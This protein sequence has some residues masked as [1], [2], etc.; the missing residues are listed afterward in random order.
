MNSNALSNLNVS[1][2]L[3][4]YN[5]NFVE[6]EIFQDG[7]N[8]TSCNMLS[9]SGNTVEFS[10]HHFTNYTVVEGYVAPQNINTPGSGSSGSTSGNYESSSGSSGSNTGSSTFTNS[11]LQSSANSV[12][13]SQNS[14][15]GNNQQTNNSNSAIN[16]I[17]SIKSNAIYYIIAFVVIAIITIISLL[18][19]NKKR[20]EKE[21]LE[22]RSAIENTDSN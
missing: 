11:N 1:A 16:T 5:I 15:N 3:T 6:P 22:L 12:I 21:S 8:C 18:V 13:S 7:I 20:K 17:N 14:V 19:I 9:Y 4:F 10:V 2:N